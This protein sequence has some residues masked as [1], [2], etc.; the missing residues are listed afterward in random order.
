VA[1]LIAAAGE[2]ISHALGVGGRDLTEAVGGLMMEAVLQA[3]AADPGT[4]VICLV[5]KPAGP[6]IARRVDEWG[7]RTGKAYVVHV[8]GGGAGGGPPGDSGDV[9][10]TTAA[11]DRSGGGLARYTA[12]T[13][14]DAAL[15]AVA[16]ARGDT[17]VPVE[18]S[19]A[20]G[21]IERIAGEAIATLGAD[22][23]FV[24][25]VYAG[26]TLAWEAVALLA[27]RLAGVAPG[28]AGDGPGHRVVDLGDDAFT[29]GRPHPM[30]DGALR[31]E[32]IAREA[33]DPATAVVLL[34][35]VLGHGAHRD[36]AAEVLPALRAAREARR[37]AGEDLA[38]VA[39]VCGT[40]ADPQNRAA[41]V[42]ALESAGV[43]VMPSNAQAARLAALLAARLARR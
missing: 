9:P 31:R 32:W 28:V 8:P 36:P 29:V 19:R 15:A 43:I 12:G 7:A 4:E 34:D 11:T 40:D 21:E 6:A 23:R 22:Q 26:G 18:F 30:I 1:C 5:G 2:G 16:L 37:R 38:V 10:R 33:S 13:L 25:G 27:S 35:V 3:L 14:E 39:S 24:R 41:Q 17:P 42:R 20:S